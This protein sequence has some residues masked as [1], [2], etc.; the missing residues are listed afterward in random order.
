MFERNSEFS[1]FESLEIYFTSCDSER[2]ECNASPLVPNGKVFKENYFMMN[3][4]TAE[5][6]LSNNE[7]PVRHHRRKLANFMLNPT[8]T[9]VKEMS[10]QL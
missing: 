1:Q 5:V 6:D 7:K 9:K 10:L 2:A 4:I 8:R 3:V